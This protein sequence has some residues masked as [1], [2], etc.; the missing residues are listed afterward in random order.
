MLNTIL[1]SIPTLAATCNIFAGNTTANGT[2]LK[3]IAIARLVVRIL[4]IVIPILL[5]IV[6]SIDLAKAVVAGKED[7]IKKAQK[8][9]VKRVIAAVIVFLIPFLLGV[10]LNLVNAKEWNECWNAA[11]DSTWNDL[12]NGN[13]LDIN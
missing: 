5:I 11:K 7:D 2:F 1:N 13:P 10:I 12:F 8:P 9:F 4:Q 6:G 3:V